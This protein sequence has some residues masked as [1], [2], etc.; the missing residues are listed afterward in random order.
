MSLFNVYPLFDIM[1]VKAQDVYI[2]DEKGTRYLDLMR[3]YTPSPV[4]RDKWICQ[5]AHAKTK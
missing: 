2:F 3:S 5:I 4:P 1:P